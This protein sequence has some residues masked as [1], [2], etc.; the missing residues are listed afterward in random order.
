MKMLQ[1]KL[2]YA[3]KTNMPK[4]CSILLLCCCRS[5]T[6]DNASRHPIQVSNQFS[7]ENHHKPFNTLI[8][9]PSPENMYRSASKAHNERRF[10][11]ISRRSHICQRPH[12]T[13][14]H[15]HPNIFYPNNFAS[16]IVSY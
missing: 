8:A 5:I 4:P 7:F 1:I 10:F 2:V 11:L 12:L 6:N 13:I 16:R 14:E 9:P 15:P 3:S